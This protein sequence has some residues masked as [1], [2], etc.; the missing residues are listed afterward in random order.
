[1]F[2]RRSF[3]LLLHIFLLALANPAQAEVTLTWQDC[4]TKAREQNIDLKISHHEYEVSKFSEGQVFGSFLPQVTLGSNYAANQA[5]EVS[6]AQTSSIVLSET[7]FSGWSD[8]SRYDQAKFDRK[9]S[10]YN[11]KGTKAQLTFDLRNAVAQVLFARELL[12]LNEDFVKKRKQNLKTVELLFETGRENRSTH[13]LMKSFYQKAVLDRD[14]AVD[15]LKL[16]LKDLGVILGIPIEEDIVLDQKITFDSIISLE[17]REKLL[18]IFETIKNQKSIAQEIIESNFD[19]QRSIIA[20]QSAKSKITSARSDFFPTIVLNQEFNKTH[21]YASSAGPD[22]NGAALTISLSMSLFTGG[23]DYYGVKISS[24]QYLSAQLN[25]MRVKQRVERQLSDSLLQLRRT[26]ERLNVER[27]GMEAYRLNEKVA[28]QQYFN[29]FITFRD[30][31][32][33]FN[34]LADQELS[35]YQGQLDLVLAQAQVELLTGDNIFD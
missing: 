22:S 13:L 24:E 20:E 28:N 1:M 15:R 21:D 27:D 34:D 3:I 10:E 35:Y 26:L 29:S 31:N 7:L 23:Q 32:W 12:N 17:N 30:W 5:P 8:M 11:L 18:K 33:A 16:A 14:L 9:A 19:Y 25:T 6:H 4:I 2:I